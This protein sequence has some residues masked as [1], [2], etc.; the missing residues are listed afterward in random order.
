MNVT[1]E[2]NSLHTSALGWTREKQRNLSGAVGSRLEKFHAMSRSARPK[3]TALTRPSFSASAL[4]ETGNQICTRAYSHDSFCAKYSRSQSIVNWYAIHIHRIAGVEDLFQKL[5]SIARK[6]ISS[7]LHY[8]FSVSWLLWNSINRSRKNDLSISFLSYS[9][10]L[11][12]FFFFLFCEITEANKFPLR[13][14]AIK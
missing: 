13:Y 5:I 3:T 8:L 12:M 11:Q 1:N 2:R 6:I 14:N 4:H 10:L 7:A 9:L